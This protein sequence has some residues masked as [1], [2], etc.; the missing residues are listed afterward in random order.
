MLTIG[1]LAAYTG[2]TV[3]AI[4]HYHQRG[5]LTEPGRDASSY[6]RQD[7]T[8]GETPSSAAVARLSSHTAG[9]LSAW[10]RMNALSRTRLESLR[11]QG[12]AA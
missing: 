9:S 12:G 3:R 1:Q 4:R 5:L 11:D 6:R 2:V 10:E 8:P 7:T